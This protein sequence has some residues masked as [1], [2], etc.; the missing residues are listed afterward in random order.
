MMSGQNKKLSLP[1][2]AKVLAVVV[3]VSVVLAGLISVMSL[4]TSKSVAEEGV[5]VMGAEVTELASGGMAGAV[6]FRKVEDIDERMEGI[7]E[8]GGSKIVGIV[9][10]DSEGQ[11][12]TGH[13]TDASVSANL[14]ESAVEAMNAGQSI[15]DQGGFL[16]AV[17]I[18]FGPEETVVGALAIQWTPEP[19]LAT[20]SQQTW[21]Q[22][23]LATIALLALLGLTAVLLHYTLSRPLKRIIARTGALA[24]GDFSSNVQDT[25]R[26]DEIGQVAQ[27][28]KELSGQLA[29]AEKLRIDSA[30][31]STGF[32]ASSAAMVMADADMNITSANPAFAALLRSQLENFRTRFPAMDPDNLIGTSVDMFHANPGA[33]RD[34]LTS[35]SF[36][37]EARVQ[38]GDATFQLRINAVQGD[39]GTIDGFVV[40][41]QDVTELSKTYAIL[42][43]LESAQLRAD[44]GPDGRLRSMNQAFTA[45]FGLAK[46]QI[47]EIRL[48]QALFTESGETLGPRLADPHAIVQRFKARIRG[49]D[50]L[51]DGSLSPTT[52][53]YG[54]VNG[55]VF[56]GRDIT[57][58]EAKLAAA[59]AE[60][61]RLAAEQRK[62]VDCL[63]RALASLSQGNLAARITEQLSADYEELRHDFNAAVEALDAAVLDIVEGAATILS[64]SGNIAGAA[65][66]LSRRT[67][68]QAATL[69]Q[70]A[71][72]ISE[73]TA[74]VASAAEGAKQAN[75]VVNGAR[76]N[77]EASGAV[78]QQAVEAMSKIENSSEQ[79]S[80]IISVIDDIAFQTNLLAL[81]AGVEAAR[82]GDAGRGFAVVASEVRGLAQRSSDAARE[83]TD[84]ISTSGEHVKQGVSLVGRAGDALNEIVGSVGG[85]AEHVSAIATSAREQSTGLEEINQAMNRLDQVTQ[86]NVAMFE[87]TTAA[88]RTMT[89]E[90]NSLVEVT[91]RFR[92]SRPSDAAAR[93]APA[94]APVA[95]A[96]AAAAAQ[97][98][99]SAPRVARSAAVPASDGTLALASAPDN[100]DWEEF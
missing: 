20:I 99:A 78:V 19:F 91:N 81:N 30:M 44:F 41:W 18:T 1:L 93:P 84:L 29:E 64:E 88:S 14:R 86:K 100:D 65:D 15:A 75:D 36:P 85:I 58:A 83:I 56:L 47:S 51:L 16:R 7:L 8:G 33:T 4:Q 23:Y 22:N 46:G 96:S 82:A 48:D 76:Q 25:G 97:E 94:A 2:F 37:H 69:E 77:A 34:R 32:M 12:L 87:E 66:D 98:T 39:E 68:Q 57:G 61:E 55:H 17:P 27:S 63:R 52:D 72:A 21:R 13:G 6:R 9:V 31:K 50:R 79:I 11:R 62:V 80:R 89:S 40:E 3:L 49:A 67:E 59:S 92:T 70:T 74:S 71:A 53:A 95:R 43:A 28:I 73:L 38:I 24:A 54:K 60:N 35:I 26:G 90:A 10:V 45:A 5:R 42:H